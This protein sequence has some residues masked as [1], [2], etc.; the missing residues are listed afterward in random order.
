[1]LQKFITVNCIF[2]DVKTKIKLFKQQ[3]DSLSCASCD[4][5]RKDKYTRILF[6]ACMAKLAVSTALFSFHGGFYFIRAIPCQ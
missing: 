3:P 6:L 4:N 5:G 2:S 1:M